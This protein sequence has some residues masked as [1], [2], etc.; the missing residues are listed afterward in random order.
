MSRETYVIRDGELVPK[1]LAAPLNSSTDH[2]F[3]P[4][5]KP[6]VL[7]DGTELSSRS[8]LREYETKNGVRQL[9]N[10][11]PG[12]TKPAFWDAWQRGELRG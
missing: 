4:D 10:D 7:P 12:S 9:G 5:M 6:V 2:R 8:K 1:H 3:I 11:W